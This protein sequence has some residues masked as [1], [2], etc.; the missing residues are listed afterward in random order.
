MLMISPH[1][2]MVIDLRVGDYPVECSRGPGNLWWVCRLFR[3]HRLDEPADTICAATITGAV[4]W[5]R[6]RVG[7]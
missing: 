1:P 3:S 6:K 2:E 4:L 7:A 5:L